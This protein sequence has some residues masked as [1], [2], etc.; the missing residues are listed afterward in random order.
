MSSL[1]MLCCLT[2]SST[3]SGA[4]EGS[5]FSQVMSCT[6]GVNEGRR[7]H[8]VTGQTELGHNSCICLWQAR[9]IAVMLRSN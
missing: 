7:W 9:L 4:P 1:S 2:S 3:I 6:R 8:T 5:F